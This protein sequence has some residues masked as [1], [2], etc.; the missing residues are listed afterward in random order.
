MFGKKE[1][2]N[3]R[4]ELE[5][6]DSVG[7]SNA[8]T[9]LLANINF[10]SVDKPI[11]VIAIT[12]T[13]PN[14]GKTTITLSLAKAIGLS[15]KTCLIVEGDMRR[16]SLRSTLGAHTSCGLHS[17]TTGAVTLRD[18][19]VQTR[20]LNVF[21]LDAEPGIP[22]PEA[23]LSSESFSRVVDGLKSRF[24]FVLFDTPPVGAFAD[25][26]VLS[27]IVDGTILVVREGSTNRE[28][29]K[30]TVSQLQSA[31]AEL[32]G[33]VMNGCT[34]QGLGSYGYYYGYYYEEKRVSASSPDAQII[35]FADEPR[36]RR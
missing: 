10:S 2:R 21:F 20:L 30:I 25:A 14:E 22:N 24:D 6:C 16:R 35:G 33:I 27:R 36:R 5:M 29:A 1:W 7:I 9:S 13:A 4:P 18:A 34:G 17:L 15:G 3:K 26:V 28:D 11:R 32:L 23:L 31:G 12:S 19:V 8:A